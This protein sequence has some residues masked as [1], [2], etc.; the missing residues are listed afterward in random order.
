MF[1]SETWRLRALDVQYS[2][3]AHTDPGQHSGG[4]NVQLV[5]KYGACLEL[6][7]SDDG[8]DGTTATSRADATASESEGDDYEMEPD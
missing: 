8:S 4:P 5:A 1:R 2:H 7:S 6:A 3:P